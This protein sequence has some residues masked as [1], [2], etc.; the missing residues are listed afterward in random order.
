MKKLLAAALTLALVLSLGTAVLAD[1]PTLSDV[2]ES[3]WFYTEVSAMID[4]GYIDGYEDGAFRPGRDVSVAEFVTMTAKCLGI[5]T[6]EEYG[7]WAGVQMRNAYDLGWLT[8]EDCAWSQFNDPVHRQLAAKI[9]AVALDLELTD[10]IPYSDYADVGQDYVPYVGAMCKAG[11]FDGFEDGTIR[12]GEILTRAQAA[13]LIYRAAGQELERVTTA[14]DGT[15][16]ASIVDLKGYDNP[17]F[18]IEVSDGTAT[19]T[20][21]HAELWTDVADPNSADPEEAAEGQRRQQITEAM[22]RPRA[23]PADSD[24]TAVYEL[25]CTSWFPGSDC[26]AVVAT[27]DGRWYRV[28][29]SGQNNNGVPELT[30]ITALSGKNV[31]ALSWRTTTSAEGDTTYMGEDYIVAAIDNSFE[32]I[33][34]PS[35]SA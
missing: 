30:E 26:Y 17:N 23:I 31:T 22:S 25:P 29:L 32:Q 3:D 15:P 16:F 2:H 24:V 8:E 13:T 12:P 34:W 19:V 20:I 4:A 5:E 10:E 7:H 1:T 27:A 6:G 11:L 14:P 21:T 35:E 33:V 28:D 9:L 18:S